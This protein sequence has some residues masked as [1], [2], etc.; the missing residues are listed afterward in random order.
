MPSSLIDKANNL[1]SSFTKTSSVEETIN[2]AHEQ[3]VPNQLV[4]PQDLLDEGH[5]SYIM[6]H[7]NTIT[8]STIKKSQQK[9]VENASEVGSVIKMLTGTQT[10]SIHKEASVKG[11]M[12]RSK[13]WIKL[14][15]PENVTSAMQHNWE[16]TEIGVAAR[17]VD[18]GGK[19]KDSDWGSAYEQASEAMKDTVARMGQTMSPMQLK[20]L[21]DLQNRTLTN[22]YMEVLYKGTEH[23]THSFEFKFT[24]KN[25]IESKTVKEIIETFKYY[26]AP[27]F[28]DGNES[29]LVYPSTFDIVFMLGA[30]EHP[31]IA[32]ASTSALTNIEVDYTAEGKFATIKDGTPVSVKVSLNFTELEQLTKTRIEEGKF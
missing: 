31:F 24:P 32:Q 10:G 28:K 9:S 29:Q 26:S 23:R 15:M 25:E 3:L 4:Y 30:N 11:G 1:V 27:E 14:Y 12:K 16:T 8:G 22:P 2:K 7:I 18:F 5:K 17:L 21:K 19:V 13:V 6:F 20:D